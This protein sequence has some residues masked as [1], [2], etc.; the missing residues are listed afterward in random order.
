MK[1]GPSLFTKI[2]TASGPEELFSLAEEISLGSKTTIRPF[3]GYGVCQIWL[4]HFWTTWIHTLQTLSILNKTSPINDHHVTLCNLIIFSCNECWLHCKKIVQAP[5]CCIL[6]SLILA[7]FSVSTHTGCQHCQVVLVKVPWIYDG[8][9]TFGMHYI[10]AWLT[11]EA[12]DMFN[13]AKSLPL[14]DRPYE[15]RQEVTADTA[16]ANRKWEGRKDG[17]RH[18]WK[19]GL[20]R[21]GRGESAILH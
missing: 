21:P 20:R 7:H 9:T 10:L 17:S 8:I 12:T 11:C 5:P 3:E 14:N 13:L 4:L 6:T 19:D 15:K 18:H 16:V 1:S 2:P